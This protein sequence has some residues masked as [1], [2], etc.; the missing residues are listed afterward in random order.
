MSSVASFYF[1]TAPSCWNL[2]I[3]TSLQDSVLFS[4]DL[5]NKK[6]DPTVLQHET[7]KLDGITKKKKTTKA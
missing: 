5:L 2:Q 6:I 7:T 4:N 3:N 1:N